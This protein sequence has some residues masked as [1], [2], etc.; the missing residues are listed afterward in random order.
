MFSNT[1]ANS[2][3]GGGTF[4]TAAGSP[5]GQVQTG[6]SRFLS[7]LGAKCLFTCSGFPCAQP[8]SQ[9]NF[10]SH[11]AHIKIV[12]WIP[13]HAALRRPQSEAVWKRR[14][15]LLGDVSGSTFSSCWNGQL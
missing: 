2:P 3:S 14:G 13:S 6:S 7:N 5:I 11:W 1:F 8:Q 15:R 4:R 10:G 9:T 12:S